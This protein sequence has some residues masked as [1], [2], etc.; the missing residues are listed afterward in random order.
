MMLSAS[1]VL[2][3]FSTSSFCFCGTLYGLMFGGLSSSLR[4]ISWSHAL[5]GGKTV[6]VEKYPHIPVTMQQLVEVYQYL[7]VVLMCHVV[8]LSDNITLYISSAH[9]FQF[10]YTDRSNMSGCSKVL[11]KTTSLFSLSEL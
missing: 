11:K 1:I 6:L 9:L 10:R 4:G 8:W 3:R 7:V 5:C 2:M